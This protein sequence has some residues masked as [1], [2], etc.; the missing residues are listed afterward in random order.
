M[1]NLL[2][3]FI[4]WKE[5][6]IITAIYIILTA[7]F[8]AVLL[9]M[10]NQYKATGLYA[11]SPDSQSSNLGAL[12]G[13]LGGL[14]SMAGI[15]LGGNQRDNMQIAIETL[16]SKQFIYQLVRENELKVDIFAAESWDPVTEKVTY[17]DSL[18]DIKN[19]TWVRDV[20]PP[21]SKQPSDFE[22]FEK[23]KSNL[24]IKQDEKTNMVKVSYVH[25]SAVVAKRIVN[26]MVKKINLSMQLKEVKEAETSISLLNKATEKT[27]NSEMK[28][29][30]FELV[31]EQT[32]R[33]LLAKTKEF[34]ILEPI[35]SPIKEENKHSPKRALILIA[36]SFVFG[37]LVLMY[38][39]FRRKS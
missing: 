4:S 23:F 6:Q 20:E 15:N 9:S 5:I 11:P 33:L 25:P 34:Y 38:L 21:K 3:K 32:K 13:S 19:E 12:S 28:T 26:L 2:L 14:A 31:Q 39:F 16:K 37:C 18:Y 36:Y 7:I 29:L 10:P 27:K 8:I 17:D 35:D 24:A 1:K 30:L 22:V